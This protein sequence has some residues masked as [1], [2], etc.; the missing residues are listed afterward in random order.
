MRESR[1][2]AVRANGAGYTASTSASEATLIPPDLCVSS[3]GWTGDRL[4]ETASDDKCDDD[5]HH[6]D[7]LLIP[8]EAWHVSAAQAKSV[9]AKHGLAN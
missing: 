6:I 9:A 7:R 2:R 5:P 3:D 1:P 4:L 8:I